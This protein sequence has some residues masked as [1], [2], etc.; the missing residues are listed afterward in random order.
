MT[1]FVKRGGKAARVKAD[2]EVRR[3][4]AIRTYGAGSLM[5][6]LNRAVLVGGLDFWQFGTE[7]GTDLDEPRLREAVTREL[8]KLDAPP[9]LS[10]TRPFLLPPTGL[11]GEP[12]RG[13]GVEVFEFPTWFVCQACRSLA[14]PPHGLDLKA[15]RWQHACDDGTHN[16][17]VPVRFVMA[18]RNGHLDEV[19]WLYFVHDGNNRPRCHSPRLRLLEGK[20][21]D[22]SEVTVA[23]ACGARRELAHAI[24]PDANPACKGYRPWL[25]PEG[26]EACVDGKPRLMMR[27]ASNTYFPQVMSA[28]TIPEEAARIDELVRGA[29]DIL[30]TATAATLPV[31]RSIPRLQALAG[32]TDGEILAAIARVTTP[33]AT[34]RPPLRTAEFVQFVS[35]PDHQPGA[36]P[37]PGD[38]FFARRFRP[39]EGLPPQIAQL[40]LAARLREVSVQLGFTRLEASTPDLQG[41]YDLG[42]TSC[43]LGLNTDW[44]PAA[45]SWGEGV[46]VQLD[47]A[48]VRAW[49]DRP[50]VQARAR[51]L[52][53]G[54]DAWAKDRTKP[55]AFPGARFY[56]LHSLAHLLMTAIAVEC[57][58][59]SAALKE[60]IYCAHRDDAVPM[61]AVLISTGTPGTEGTLGG[62]VEQ[63][64]HL[65]AHLQRAF[66]LG[67][68]C[69]TDPVCAFHQP[70]TDPTR[71]HREGA[72]CHGCL[73]VAEPSCEWAN[74]SLDRALVV[75]V[76]GQPD[77]VAFFG[78]RPAPAG[79]AG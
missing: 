66:D 76:M 2:G 35:Q 55:G 26:Q 74:V 37:G 22:F 20:A 38:S 73:Y 46:F 33:S 3:S 70:A 45:E 29:M 39:A 43:R 12:R 14:K 69:S 17:A 11:D 44:L 4:Q 54:F 62:L 59:S 23:C 57:G 48:A 63:G 52:A 67:R 9:V 28:L 5:D 19:P 1:K 31:F 36:L 15:D 25:G 56:L 30:A 58:Y 13:N 71:R 75:P 79:A 7:G 42:A 27:G 78:Q 51:T 6:L 32:F 8:D 64:Q 21:G 24:S 18:C 40:V 65:L 47:E 77:G 50:E 53:A 34:P 10:K 61:A 49:E 72:A 16:P 68:L 60:R 41:Q